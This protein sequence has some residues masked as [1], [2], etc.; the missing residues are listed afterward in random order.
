MISHHISQHIGRL[1][2]FLLLGVLLFH[3]LVLGG[4]IPYSIVWGGRLNSTAQMVAFELVSLVVNSGIIMIVLHRLGRLHIFKP[5]MVTILLYLL[6]VVFLLNTVGN[7]ASAS[8][9]EKMIF[10]PLTALL[11]VGMFFLARS[12]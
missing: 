3:S 4:V 9:W 2:V 11:A 1:V 5:G 10:T 12:K 6:S 7:L 8:Y